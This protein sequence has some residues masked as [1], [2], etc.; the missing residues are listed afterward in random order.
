MTNPSRNNRGMT[1]NDLSSLSACIPRIH[2][3]DVRRMCEANTEFAA[4]TQAI[5]EAAKPAV[6]QLGRD[7][8]ALFSGLAMR[9]E[10][11]R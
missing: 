5:F 2:P 7:I 4:Q 11:G 6:E 10:R 8:G 1:V 3:D 9:N